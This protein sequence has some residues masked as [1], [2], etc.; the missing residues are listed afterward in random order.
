MSYLAIIIFSFLVVGGTLVEKSQDNQE[1]TK[2]IEVAVKKPVETKPAKE[3][4]TPE[5][6]KEEVTPEPIKEEAKAD[7]E[8]IKKDANTDEST[9]DYLKFIMYIIA[10]IAAIFAGWYFF[11][12][13]R[14]TQSL[15]S[16]TVDDAIKDSEV[17][18]QTE[19]TEP[20]PV[21]EEVQTETTES[22]QIDEDENNKK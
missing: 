4:V 17:V 22:Q 7:P 16:S 3:E 14:N 9:N 2:K 15:T 20:Q 12:N 8:P 1:E 5:P 10:G 6:V 18:Y 11:S 19:T 21:E 13:K